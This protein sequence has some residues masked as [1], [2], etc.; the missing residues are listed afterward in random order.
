M[1]KMIILCSLALI[2]STLMGYAADKIIVA[3]A[4][5]WAP[6]ADPS[7]PR[8]GISLAIIRA[9]Y[10]TQGYTVKMV[11]VPWARAEQGVTRGSFDILPTVWKSDAR[12]KV[13]EFSEPY[14]VNDIKFIKTIDDDFEYTDLSSLDGKRV[15]TVRGYGYGD[16]FLAAKN[17]KRE[18]VTSL[19]QNIAKLTHENKRIDL[20]LDDE[21][22]ARVTIANEDPQLLEKVR[23]VE[24]PY[25][26]KKLYVAAGLANPRHKEIISAF[27]T[28]L[29][30]IE[31]N[32][33]LEEIRKSYGLE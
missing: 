19:V 8:E 25:S 27:N 3:A 4:D 24:T 18:E 21:I 6:F 32:G 33:K 7:D 17:F 12:L 2:A 23:F 13:L 31:A 14:A 16:E 26:S 5:P 15:G 29:K 11:Y 20:T 28:G 9:A 10:Q 22:V 1:K 30:E